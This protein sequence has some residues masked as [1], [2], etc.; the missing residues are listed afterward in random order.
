MSQLADVPLTRPDRW[1]HVDVV[2][3]AIVAI[4][5]T[6]LLFDMAQAQASGAFVLR[7]V[8]SVAPLFAVSIGLIAFTSASGV[9][10][11]I[12]KAFVGRTSTMIVLAALTGALSPFC[13]CGVIP[14]VAALLQM[15]VPLPAVMAFWLASPLMDP[16]QFALTVSVLGWPF[17]VAKTIAAIAVGLL[18]GFGAM[19]IQALGGLGAVLRE[20]VGNGGCAAAPVRNPKAVVWAF[21][22]EPA[23]LSRA[24]TGARRNGLFLGK[25]LVLA[26]VL[27]SLMSAWM[28][29]GLIGRVLGGDGFGAIL[30]ATLIGI[31]AY[32][33]GTAALPLV[34]ELM[35]QGMAPGAAM[36]FLIGGGVTSIP[37]AIAVW[38]VARPTV[39]A[40]YLGL[41]ALGAI[42]SGLAWQAA[43]SLL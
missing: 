2:W 13:S 35:Q 38:S 41:A 22:R 42:L 24:V 25:M 29:A 37:A 6:L 15:G 11:L 12:S 27:E 4:F 7:A 3:A 16:A 21:W 17:A 1:L 10:N 20:G 39:F 18:G 43:Q 34:R 40:V 23:R 9:D 31:P 30:L 5:I 32:L 26:F 8:A 33:N 36:A 19:A 14:L 28:P